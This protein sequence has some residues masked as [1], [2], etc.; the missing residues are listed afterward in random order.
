MP[1]CP[2]GMGGIGCKGLLLC[3]IAVFRL[4]L[5]HLTPE[6]KRSKV[7]A[8]SKVKA[9]LY[10]WSRVRANIKQVNTLTEDEDRSTGYIGSATPLKRKDITSHS[11]ILP[12]ATT[13]KA[14]ILP[15]LLTLAKNRLC[16]LTLA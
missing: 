1:P 8:W 15:C 16:S 9:K 14:N 5:M 2:S 6:S 11:P 12:P 7:A 4:E 10:S 13:V 3:P